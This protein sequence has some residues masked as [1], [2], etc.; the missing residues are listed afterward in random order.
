[1]K[2]AL[3]PTPDD[4]T[5]TAV[6]GPPIIRAE[7]PLCGA[8]LVPWLSSQGIVAGGGPLAQSGSEQAVGATAEGGPQSPLTH[9]LALA[10]VAARPSEPTVRA[11]E[12][13]ALAATRLA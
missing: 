8:R 5:D 2:A 12:I 7:D 11:A 10:A 4:A 3:M 6:P 13:T 1:L 9:S